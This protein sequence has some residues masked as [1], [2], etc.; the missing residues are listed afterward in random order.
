M[1]R[2]LDLTDYLLQIRNFT[3]EDVIQ[4]LDRLLARREAVVEKIT[5]YQGRISS[6]LELQYEKLKS[7]ALTS[8]LHE[9]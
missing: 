2:D 9:N 4:A 8:R 6:L 7:F 1:M 5:S 3:A